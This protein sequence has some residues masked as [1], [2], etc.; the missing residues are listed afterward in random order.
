MST[1]LHESVL[2]QSDRLRTYHRTCAMAGCKNKFTTNYH[3]QKYCK[4]PECDAE[5]AKM[6]S[7]MRPK[8]GHKKAPL[9][10]TALSA[11]FLS[12]RF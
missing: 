11:K 5:V 12:M 9:P 4:T 2:R 7:A 10:D 3:Y 6:R 1:G 8:T